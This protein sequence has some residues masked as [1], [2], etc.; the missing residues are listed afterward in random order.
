M[1]IAVTG[2]GGFVGRGICAAL[3]ARGDQVTAVVRREAALQ[4]VPAGA[5]PLLLENLGDEADLRRRLPPAQCLIHA[6]GNA[7]LRDSGR[8]GHPQAEVEMA[9]ALARAAA[10]RGYRRLVFISSIAVLG[11]RDGDTPF[12]ETTPAAPGW[13]Y[14]RIKLEAEQALLAVGRESGIET[15]ILRPPL[16]YGQDNRGNF[17]RL[18]RWVASGLPIPL[19]LADNAR[20]YIYLGNLADAAALSARHPGAANRLFLL[21]DARDWSTPEL[22]RLI[23]RA[24]RCAARLWPV[25]LGILRALGQAAGK[26]HEVGSLINSRRID[27]TLIR[28][29]TG[30]VPP[31]EAE[32]SLVRTVRWSL[33]NPVSG[34]AR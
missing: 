12:T 5:V 25:P 14:A 27:T 19:G 18:V 4:A 29:L 10:A 20:S 28:Q 1:D 33:D 23:A 22:V 2:A 30:W 24:A 11:T 6:A 15:V 21:A 34:P 31:H 17:P 26:S 3:A 13:P 16:V 7:S 8:T 32:E 9:R